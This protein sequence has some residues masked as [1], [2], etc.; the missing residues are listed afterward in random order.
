MLFQVRVAMQSA[1]V[2]GAAYPAT[3]RIMYSF[4]Y[5]LSVNM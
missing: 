5:S 1:E 2:D 3:F 4:F